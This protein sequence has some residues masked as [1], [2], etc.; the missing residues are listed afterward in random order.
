MLVHCAYAQLALALMFEHARTH[1][2][3][4]SPSSLAVSN[5]QA[6]Y[7]M[8]IAVL[9]FMCGNSSCKK[10]SIARVHRVHACSYIAHMHSS[11][12]RSCLST[13]AQSAQVPSSLAVSNQQASWLYIRAQA[14]YWQPH[15]YIAVYIADKSPY[16]DC[17]LT[18]LCQ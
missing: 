12:L 14:K 5:Q 6:S 11:H 3:R 13:H 8:P 18:T 17:C 15:A 1:R 4:R 2:V 9:K 10:A 7:V 16:Q